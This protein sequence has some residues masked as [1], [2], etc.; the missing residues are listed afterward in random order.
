MTYFTKAVLT[1]GA[2]AT[3]YSG[4]IANETKEE[5]N[6]FDTYNV[7]FVNN[8]TLELAVHS[9]YTD[10]FELCERLT[11]DINYDKDVDMYAA[12]GCLYLLAKEPHKAIASIET[13]LLTKPRLDRELAMKLSL[14]HAYEMLG[15]I[16]TAHEW[17]DEAIDMV[18]NNRD[19]LPL[20]IITSSYFRSFKSFYNN[21]KIEKAKELVDYFEVVAV[22]K[23]SSIEDIQTVHKIYL[24]MKLLTALDE[25]ADN[26]R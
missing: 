14:G 11:D 8:S 5:N 7:K 6:V 15:A 2:V 21:D 26:E 13:Y 19:N 9:Y 10:N 23:N 12:K 24:M 1:L 4:A 18:N 17:F 3:L 25:V 22:K 20:D 16:D